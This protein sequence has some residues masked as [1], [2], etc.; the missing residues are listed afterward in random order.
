[1][2][3]GH[4]EGHGHACAERHAHAPVLQSNA[5]G[6]SHAASERNSGNEGREI[7]LSWII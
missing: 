1:M 3:Q 7:L 5:E 2:P 4:E 6:T